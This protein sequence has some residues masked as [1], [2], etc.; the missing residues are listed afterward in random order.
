[1]QTVCDQANC[2]NSTLVKGKCILHARMLCKYPFCYNLKSILGVH[3]GKHSLSL[4]GQIYTC[5]FM[6]TNKV[7]LLCESH[8]VWVCRTKKKSARVFKHAGTGSC[9]ICK[10]VNK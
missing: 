3:C 5:V 9:A 8:L 6:Q 4:A 10:V 7:A 2:E 1:M